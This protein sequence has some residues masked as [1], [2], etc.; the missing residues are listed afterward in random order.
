MRRRSPQH[1][2]AFDI[3]CVDGKDLRGL[4]LVKRKQILRRAV[5]SQPAPL[6]YVDHFAGRGVDLFR[7]V[8]EQDLEGIVAKHKHGLYPPEKTSWV[9]INNRAYSQAEGR[10]EFFEVR[11]ARA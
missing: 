4:P 8:C 2:C 1:F 5:P 9:K 7:A 10:H 3:L 11:A 6:L